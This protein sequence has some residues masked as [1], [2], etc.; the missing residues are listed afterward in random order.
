MREVFE[1]VITKG[2]NGIF[3]KSGSLDVCCMKAQTHK[4]FLMALMWLVV[5]GLLIVGSI[6]LFVHELL[7]VIANW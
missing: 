6:L 3:V 1:K 2:E 7:R 4:V 5:I